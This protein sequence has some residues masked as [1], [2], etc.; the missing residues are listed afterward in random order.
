MGVSC[1]LW[2]RQRSNRGLSQDKLAHVAVGDPDP[3]LDLDIAN[4][5]LCR[6]E[7]ADE[8]SQT[9]IL[10]WSCTRERGHRG[11]HVAGTGEWVAAVHPQLLP[12][13]TAASVSA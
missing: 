11:Q 2:H 12:M 3:T 1:R 9:L 10:P 6:F 13:A 5:Y 7:W 8:A 4:G